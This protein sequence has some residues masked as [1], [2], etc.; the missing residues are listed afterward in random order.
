VQGFDG[1]AVCCSSNYDGCH[2][3]FMYDVPCR[4]AAAARCCCLL[5]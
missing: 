4:A 1:R 5:L 2:D 3:G